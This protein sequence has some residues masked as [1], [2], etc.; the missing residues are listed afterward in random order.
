M[1]EGCY[2]YAI[3]PRGARLP[4]RLV[5]FGGPLTAVPWRA[6]A[7]ATSWLR[8]AELARTREHLLR[9]EA[10]V[11]GLRRNGPAL[12]VRFGTVLP[13][14]HA[15][16]GAIARCYPALVADMARLGDKVELDVA[17]MGDAAGLGDGALEQALGGAPEGH[18]AVAGAGR[19]TRYLQARMAEHRAE[20]LRRSQAS[21]LARALDAALLPLA[22][23]SR[24]TLF[25]TSRL[26]L[27][28]AYLLDSAFLGAFRSAFN[29]LRRENPTYPFALSGP[30]PPYSF[31]T[32]PLQL[33][34]GSRTPARA[35]GRDTAVALGEKEESRGGEAC[36]VIDPGVERGRVAGLFST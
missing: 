35:E 20:G 32:A 22:L 27:N 8:P 33:A 30:W 2:V 16:E 34:E 10:V 12:P 9:H 25:P 5:G 18:A 11:E 17:V 29:R 19:G 6:L 7:A 26:A 24:C 1:A 4:A 28:V 14:P 13:N 15:V 36:M 3:L 21:G 23:E 31:V